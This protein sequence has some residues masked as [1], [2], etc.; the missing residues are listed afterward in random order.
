M[1]Q[2]TSPLWMAGWVGLAGGAAL[3][4]LGLVAADELSQLAGGYGLMLMGAATYLLGGL[5][6]RESLARR[7]RELPRTTTPPLATGRI[8]LN[9]P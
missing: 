5:G 4:V 7:S 3:A 9:Q 6:L 2:R 1:K 8:T